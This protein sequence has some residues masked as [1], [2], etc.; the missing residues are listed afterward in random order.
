MLFS[1]PRIALLTTG[2]KNAT[3]EGAAGDAEEDDEFD[4][5]HAEDCFCVGFAVGDG[6]HHLIHII[7]TRSL[8]IPISLRVQIPTNT[9]FKLIALIPSQ[10]NA[11]YLPN[12]ARIATHLRNKIVDCVDRPLLVDDRGVLEE[13]YGEDAL[14]RVVVDIEEDGGAIVDEAVEV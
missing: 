14:L 10:Y 8:P 1:P 11:R 12:N 13:F 7:I 9:L 4:P 6:L 2:A 5:D 3:G